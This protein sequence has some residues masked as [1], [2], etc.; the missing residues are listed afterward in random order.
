M[1]YETGYAANECELQEKVDVFLRGIGWQVRTQ[2]GTFDKVYYSTGEDGYN[3][4]YIR[5]RAQVS[6]PL[7]GSPNA[8]GKQ[9]DM[10]DGYSGYLN[11]FAYQYFP[12]TAD[13][14]DGYGEAGLFGPRLYWFRGSSSDA[15]YYQNIFSQD[16]GNRKWKLIG[17]QT[18][19]LT[20]DKT[21]PMSYG[22]GAFDG[23][24]NYYSSA[25]SVFRFNHYDIHNN[26]ADFITETGPASPT[27]YPAN[28]VWVLDKS[29]RK[30]YMYFTL[31][32]YGTHTISDI[33][34]D[35][36]SADMRRIDLSTGM[37]QSGFNGP[38]QVWDF[39][40]TYG[41]KSEYSHMLWDGGNFM[42]CMRNQWPAS[43]NIAKYA[44][45]TNQW[46][47][48]P[49]LPYNSETRN[50][51]LFLDKS[52]TGAAHNRLYVI[53]SA[54]IAST[55]FYL[56][57][58]DDSGDAIGI[59]TS[60]GAMP[61]QFNPFAGGVFT[62]NGM[63]RI[64]YIPGGSTNFYYADFGA[65]SLSWNLESSY[66]PDVTQNYGDLFYTD[67]YASR[68]KTTIYGNT[69]YWFAGDKDHL[70]IVTRYVPSGRNAYMA[71]EGNA[72][73]L[74]DFSYKYDCCYVGGINPHSDV[75]TNAKTTS[76][77]YSGS[78]V[79][80]PIQLFKGE[81]QIGQKMF[82]CNAT[83]KDPVVISN[84]AEGSVKNFM[85]MEQFTIT[86]VVPGVSITAN[87]L[88][89]NYPSG[90]R[91]AT[92]PQPVGVTFNGM[93]KIQ[94][95]NS[96]NTVN[97]FGSTDMAE[98]IASLVSASD[99]IVNA[100]GNSSRNGSYSLWPL[101]IINEGLEA[102]YSGTEIRGKLI[103]MF[104]VSSNGLNN[105]DIVKIGQNSYSVFNLDTARSYYFAI[106]PIVISEEE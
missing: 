21:S 82:I 54:P 88:N 40:V 8:G 17:Y 76:D 48:L 65:S 58:D 38:S 102:A 101:S 32:A 84:D 96:I 31:S 1:A 56:D 69:K 73:D 87:A 26:T 4:I 67:G 83:G 57:L 72:P 27:S 105:E 19:S 20:R 55:L 23:V 53:L 29:T 80:I 86:N 6:Q 11:F 37:I 78:S 15:V 43:N 41:Y 106:G 95:L 74:Q 49:D 47:R 33:A 24:R 60:L 12:E 7:R 75:S 90:S 100:S 42:Y 35:I 68:V 97:D 50:P 81:F 94:M 36:I 71:I 103:G 16:I 93:D 79:V 18:A 10:G 51:L 98:N 59:W 85:A 30:E 70:I 46:N 66:F 44:F 92:D 13:G 99:D 77:I 39:D 62:T 3:D 64:Y 63:N 34:P 104:A 52:L 9:M 45:E 22:R 28:L 61:E 5:S 2:I 25:S 89:G 14:Y 91:I